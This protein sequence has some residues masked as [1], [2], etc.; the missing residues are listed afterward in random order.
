MGYTEILPFCNKYLQSYSL[1]NVFITL[2]IAIAII[3]SVCI[4]GA[5]EKSSGT[6]LFLKI[7]KKIRSW[8]SFFFFFFDEYDHCIL[9]GDSQIE[10]KQLKLEKEVDKRV[11]YCQSSVVYP[12]VNY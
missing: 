1:W 12:F 11:F 3:G 8:I 10:G 4:I 2:A 9:E 5:T 7:I 6:M